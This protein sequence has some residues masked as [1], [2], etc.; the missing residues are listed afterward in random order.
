M[1]HL[2]RCI[3]FIALLAVRTAWAQP[4]N[5]QFAFVVST[6]ARIAGHTFTPTTSFEGVALNDVG[7]VAF[8]ARWQ[9]G[10]RE[11]T[12]VF[13]SKRLVARD[14]DQIDG[15]GPLS[16]ILANSLSINSGGTVAF[17]A[18]IGGAVTHTAIFVERHYKTGLAK[19]G[20]SNDFT[21]EDNGEV[22]LKAAVAAPE[23]A[24]P[25]SRGTQTARATGAYTTLQQLESIYGRRFPV[26][27]P[28]PVG[29]IPNPAPPRQTA[30]EAIGAVAPCKVPAEFPYPASWSF[31]DVM[32]GPITVHVFD[33]PPRPRPYDSPRL[34]HIVSAVRSIQCGSDGKPLLIAIAD[35]S[36]PGSWELFSP[37]GIVA[38]ARDGFLKINGFEDAI[39]AANVIGGDSPIRINRRGDIVIPVGFLSKPGFAILFAASLGGPQ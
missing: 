39:S 18:V 10:G 34:G 37:Q 28:N 16:R 15:K 20:A 26:A 29:A 4:A 17:E 12:A 30:R 11:R 25:Y 9:E 2:T 1:T 22:A 36:K 23:A 5:Y 7:E 8:V 33:A 24:S 21:L 27:I 6:G 13:T 31:G 32:S 35:S 14:G 3:L 38:F 19:S